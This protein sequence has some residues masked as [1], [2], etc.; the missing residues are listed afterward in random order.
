MHLDVIVGS[1]LGL[2]VSYMCYRQHFPALTSQ[3][4]HKPYSSNL[5]SI[6]TI[7]R[8]ECSYSPANNPGPCFSC[9]VSSSS[10]QLTDI[11]GEDTD[12]NSDSKQDD[13]YRKSNLLPI[14]PSVKWI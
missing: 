12:H 6:S 3:Y 11:L 4:S 13:S 7:Q 8:R 14:K 1:I 2:S 10:E 9:K 5:Q